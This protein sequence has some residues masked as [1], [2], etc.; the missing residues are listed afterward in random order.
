MN[1]VW[2][3]QE[4]RSILADPSQ[5]AKCLSDKT[6]V[7]HKKDHSGTNCGSSDRDWPKKIEQI[8]DLQCPYMAEFDWPDSS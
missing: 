8:I 2:S 1:L 4:N 5:T 3:G 6:F 7:K